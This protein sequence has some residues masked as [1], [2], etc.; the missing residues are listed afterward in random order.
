M[1]IASLEVVRSSPLKPSNAS[2]TIASLEVTSVSVSSANSP[3]D[4]G[5]AETCVTTFESEEA[6]IYRNGEADKA[7]HCRHGGK[8]IS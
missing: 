5:S 7:G 1:E 8:H 6:L 2:R 4:G 3:F